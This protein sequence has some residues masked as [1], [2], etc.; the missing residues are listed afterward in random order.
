M[1]MYNNI[2]RKLQFSRTMVTS[3]KSRAYPRGLERRRDSEDDGVGVRRVRATVH[4]HQGPEHEKEA[5]RDRGA[6]GAAA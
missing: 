1:Y 5:E 2:R 3:S 4:Y 6:Q